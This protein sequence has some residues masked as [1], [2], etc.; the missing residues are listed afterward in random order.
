MD[1]T[2]F[3]SLSH[4]EKPII[5]EEKNRDY[6]SIGENN[7]YYNELIECFLN[8]TTNKA[9][10][11]GISQQIYGKG[12]DATDSSEKPEE[13][14]Q[15]MELLD[16][17][18]LRK[19]CLDLK[20]LGEA[21][22]Q[23]TYKG[24][25]VATISHFPRETL[26]AEKMGNKGIIENYF[27]APNWQEVT[28]ATELQKIPVF[29]TKNKGREIKIIKNYIPGYYYYSLADYCTSYATL[30]SEVSQYLI[31]ETMSSFSSRSLI[32]FNNGVPS[33]EVQR[34]INNQ[35]KNQL[36]GSNGERVIVSFNHNA[37]AATK[38]ESIP[39]QNAPDLYEQLSNECRRM[40]Q[41]THR[42]S[43]PLLLGIRDGNASSLGSNSDEIMVA[44]RL[45]HNTTILPYQKLICE[46]LEDILSVNNITLN[47]YFKN[48]DPLEFIDV[49]NV[50]ND[51]VKEE[52]T[53]VKEDDSTEL[54]VEI[55]DKAYENI[56]SALEGEIMD[57]EEWEIADIRDYNEEN[58]SC[59]LW[60][61]SLI[62]TNLAE[63]GR[64]VKPAGKSIS[65]EKP[66]GF[67]VLDKSFYKVRYK[68]ATGV[69]KK[70]GSKSRPFCEAMMKR[71]R[72]GV[73]YRIEDIDLAS[74]YWTSED[75]KR[76]GLPMHNGKPFNLFKLKGGKYCRHVWKEVLY[77]VKNKKNKDSKNMKDYEVVETIPSSYKP[78]PRGQKRAGIAENTRSDGGAYSG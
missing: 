11:T 72:K 32:N 34:Q 61:E 13:Y 44:Q 17:D 9:V 18:C 76:L 52:E 68:Y 77:K 78:K 59:D 43:S 30:E 53:G 51:E 69:R 36:T 66:K 58:E 21:A 1:N 22:L 2:H 16:P 75:F 47:L 50:K 45:F 57:S 28:N 7:N 49:D 6:V 64:Q 20:M 24:K 54:S 63:T 60:A 10:I 5:V 74:E 56:L 38:I 48:I 41:L 15:M 8:S 39:L 65:V 14:A 55:D 71:S 35:V 40:I 73:V 25:K 26:R 46:N 67:S 42:V 31:T 19:I 3:I 4:Y 27:Y 12:L 70:K 23:V 37:E 33:P 29:G 62:E